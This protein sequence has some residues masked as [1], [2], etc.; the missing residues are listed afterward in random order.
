VILGRK[1]DILRQV[2]VVG[3]PFMLPSIRLS[4]NQKEKLNDDQLTNLAQVNLSKVI[5]ELISQKSLNEDLEIGL[6]LPKFQ[7][8]LDLLNKIK[9]LREEMEIYCYLVDENGQVR[10]I[11]PQE[12]VSE[13]SVKETSISSLVNK[14]KRIFEFSCLPKDTSLQTIY[15]INGTSKNFQLFMMLLSN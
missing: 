7:A 4:N 2:V 15:S 8:Y 5:F 3:L 12:N 10:L 6:G 9:F 1:G 13:N 11:P 14:I